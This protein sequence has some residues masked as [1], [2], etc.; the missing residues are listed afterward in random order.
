M[1]IIKNLTLR[2][3]AKLPIPNGTPF[4]GDWFKKLRFNIYMSDNGKKIGNLV[5]NL[6]SS[7]FDDLQEVVDKLEAD[8]NTAGKKKAQE[9]KVMINKGRAV[10]DKLK[11]N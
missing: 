4:I 10:S 7:L 1:K 11:S 2:A 6:T 8:E 9:L 5:A 3:I